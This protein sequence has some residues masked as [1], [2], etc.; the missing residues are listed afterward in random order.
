MFAGPTHT[1][2][3][4]ARLP[5]APSPRGHSKIPKRVVVPSVPGE[6]TSVELEVLLACARV[7]RLREGPVREDEGL[8]GDPAVAAAW[9]GVVRGGGVLESPEPAVQAGRR[10]RVHEVRLRL[11][12]DRRQVSGRPVELEGLGR[13]PR[14]V[15]AQV[16]VDHRVVVPV[17][18]IEDRHEADG[19]ELDQVALGDEGEVVRVVPG[20]DVPELHGV[21]SEGRPMRAPCPLTAE[22]RRAPQRFGGKSVRLP[23]GSPWSTPGRSVR[24]PPT[25]TP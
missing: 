4:P 20:R 12:G 21:L 17:G 2:P 11:G 25:M 5:P 13:V 8:A 10:D 3:S 9:F 6:G 18:R 15:P 19:V 24:P 1:R 23:R 14:G 7:A 16:R 22:Q